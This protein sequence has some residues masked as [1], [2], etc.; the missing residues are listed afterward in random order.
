MRDCRIFVALSIAVLLGCGDSHEERLRLMKVKAEAEMSRYLASV[1]NG[2]PK[3]ETVGEDLLNH[4]KALPDDAV[5]QELQQNLIRQMFDFDFSEVP[6]VPNRP[7]RGYAW[8]NVRLFF[9]RLL[10]R[11]SDSGIERWNLRIQYLVWARTQVGRMKEKVLKGLKAGDLNRNLFENIL[12]DYNG[13]SLNYE[14][15]LLEIEIR[16]HEYS[17]RISPDERRLMAELFEK[18]VGRVV[19]THEQCMK[20]FE[21]K[22]RVEFPRVKWTNGALQEE[23]TEEHW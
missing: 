19:R 14:W 22:Q 4:V 9:C 21:R 23:W 10:P 1:T 12:A 7:E 15:N 5:R 3:A 13:H 17:K 11:M 8:R 2:S 6:I 16:F 20:D 18:S